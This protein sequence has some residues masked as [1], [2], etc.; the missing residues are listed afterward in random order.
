MKHA[1]R[2]NEAYISLGKMMIPVQKGILSVDTAG[3]IQAMREALKAEE[4]PQEKSLKE[5]KADKISKTCK[6]K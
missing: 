4:V 3:S 2:I 1:T 5:G 6:S